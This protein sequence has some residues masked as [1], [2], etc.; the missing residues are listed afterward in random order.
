M[1][2]IV[3]FLLIA[4]TATA[5]PIYVV[6]KVAKLKK[7]NF[8]LVKIENKDKNIF[9]PNFVNYKDSS[10]IYQVGDTMQVN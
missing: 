1:R 2:K 8:L 4:N 9:C 10:R 7:Y 5:Q 3:L 6:K